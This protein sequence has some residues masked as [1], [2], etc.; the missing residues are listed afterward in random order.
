MKRILLLS[1]VFTFAFSAWAQRTVSGKVTDDGGDGLPGVNVVIKGTTTGVTTDLD[2]NYSISVSDDG[3]ILVFSSVGMADQ[4]ASVG[5]RSVIDTSMSQDAT[6][7]QEVV[8]TAIGLEVNKRDLGYSVQQVDGNE[9]NRSNDVNMVTALAGKVAGVQ[10]TSS[11]G[12][13]GASAQ[14]RIRGNSTIQGSNSPL[15]VIDGIPIDNST[16][17]TADSPEDAISS[18]GS[19]GVN[20]SNRA[21]DINPADVASMTVLKGPAATAL[22]GVRGSN[23]VVVI[24]TKRGRKG[25]TK[26]SYSFGVNFDQVNKLPDLQTSFAQGNLVDGVPTFEAAMNG[27]STGDSWGPAIADLRYSETASVWDPN[28]LIV[29][30]G[31]PLAG[32]EIPKGYNNAE[33]F[34][35]IGVTTTHNI[36]A[37]GGNDNVVYYLSIGRMQQQG[38]IPNSSFGRTSF[39][40]TLSSNLTEKLKATFSANYIESG[41]DRAQNGSNTS[42]IMLSLLRTSPSF[43]NRGGV[44]V[45]E[46]P[47]GYQ[48]ANGT[49]R[50]YRGLTGTGT[51]RYDNPYWS[52]YKNY[53]TDIVRRVVGFSSLEYEVSDWF[54]ANAKVGIDTYSDVRKLRT[55]IGSANVGV[56]QVINQAITNRDMNVDV[57]GIIKAELNS[58]LYL[59]GTI[60]WNYFDKQ[61]VNR[62]EDGQGLASR[63]FF[64]AASASSFSVVERPEAKQLYGVYADFKLTFKDMLFLNLTGRND[65]SSTLGANDNSFF[66]PAVA[67]GWAFTEN[68]DLG[69][70]IPYGKIR[71]AYGKVGNDAPFGFTDNGFAQAR[72]R[73]GWTSPNGV[74]FPALGTNSFIPSSTLGNPDLRPEFTTTL[75]IGTDLRLFEGKL[76][77]D[78]T[79]YKAV[80]E[81]AIL[82]VSLPHSSGFSASTVN[83]GEIENKGIEAVLTGNIVSSGDFSYDLSLI[84]NKYTSIVNALAPGLDVI[85]IDP[86]G[87]QRIAVGEPFGIF[88][89]TRFLRDDNGNQVIS[90]KTGLPLQDPTNGKVG[91]PTPDFTIGF[92]NTVSYKNLQLSFLI[93][94]RKGGDVYNGTSGVLNY[95]GVGAATLN[96][97]EVVTF[98]GVAADA[99]G[100]PTSAVNKVSTII[101]G[102][103]GGSNY[104][105]KYGFTGLDELTVQDGSWIRLRDVNIAYSVPTSMLSKTP[106]GAAS[107]TLTGR[108]LFLITDYTG[109]D[110]E[111]NLTGNAS[112]VIGYDYFN[113]PN[114]KSYGFKL[115]VT[116]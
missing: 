87:T 22:Y 8:V 66:Y 33:D 31:D 83:A 2:G 25:K 86:F 46:D 82:Q 105:R 55:D 16:F 51:A 89:G 91:D 34:F 44:D 6:E 99:N 93:D 110:P 68:F 4:E 101:G 52:A 107:I 5:A 94:Y 102:T 60:G 67:L 100:K 7:L 15:F 77:A 78:I 38:F 49:P 9:V 18:L 27:S 54:T 56:G 90:Q 70:A 36:S 71:V 74:L 57:Y 64:N 12:T 106:F 72:V 75:E 3:V 104:Y 35:E 61:L 97:N 62:R 45:D 23:G 88:H 79:Y 19:G 59:N 84:F 96:R 58:D 17:T 116:F 63:G 48:F 112:N 115:N 98:D 42:G 92:R 13:A 28:G 41:G 76:T 10:V 43:D 37:S 47:S 32:G 26:V 53:A 1:M 108:N 24:T 81:D 39:K 14:I 11:G 50:S 111:T 29:P 103:D 40:T 113:N 65:W 20:Q 95:F 109:I 80:T 21:I 73:D 69:N 30:A 85:K 114:T